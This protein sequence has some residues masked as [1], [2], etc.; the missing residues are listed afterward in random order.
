MLLT[1]D[2][3]LNK[4]EQAQQ[5]S[6]HPFIHDFSN[7]LKIEEVFKEIK[8]PDI[9]PGEVLPATSDF[10]MVAGEFIEIYSKQPDSWD[11]I[12]TCFFMDTANNIIQYIETIYNALKP[13]GAWINF[14]PLLYHYADMSDQLSIE[15]SWEEFRAVV[16]GIGFIIQ[17]EDQQES[18][19]ASDVNPMLRISYNCI[20]FTAFKPK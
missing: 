8:I 4:I 3:I 12:I 1:S 5:F 9:C 7:V 20:F 17:H 2:F 15:L 19:Y 14:G 11:C 6:L 18:L 16:F 10:S 13:G